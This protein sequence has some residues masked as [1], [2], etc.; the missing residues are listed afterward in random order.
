MAQCYFHLGDDEASKALFYQAY[1]IYRA[2]DDYRGA[3]LLQ[4]DAKEYYSIPFMY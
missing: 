3:A 1:Y 2:T 4:E